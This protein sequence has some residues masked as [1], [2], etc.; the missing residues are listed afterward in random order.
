[1]LFVFALLAIEG[2]SIPFRTDAAPR[3]DAV[4]G[5]AV[6]LRAALDGFSALQDQMDGVRERFST[7]VHDTLATLPNTT[8]VATKTPHACPP[9]AAE[10]YTRA[11][12]A[13][14]RFLTLGQQLAARYREIRRGEE[15]GDAAGRAADYRWKA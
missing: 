12:T 14:G 5:D 9:A 4:V 15:S 13:G 10:P 11:L 6:S 7:A 8:T 2:T 3:I 1:M